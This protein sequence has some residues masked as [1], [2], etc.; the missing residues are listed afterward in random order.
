[1]PLRPIQKLL[2][3]PCVISVL[4]GYGFLITVLVIHILWARS[5]MESQIRDMLLA[6]ASSNAAQI[7]ADALDAVDGRSDMDAPQFRELVTR[8]QAIRDAEGVSIRYAY[9]LRRTSDPMEL[10]FVADADSLLSPDELDVNR[11]GTV[12]MA[13]EASYP[14]DT[15]DVSDNDALRMR[16]FEA[17]TTDDEVTIDQWGRLLSGYAPIRRPNGTVTGVLGIDMKADEYQ[18]LIARTASPFLLLV[19]IT[20]GLLLCATSVYCVV[21]KMPKMDTNDPQSAL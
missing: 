11:N 4:A 19:V 1:M 15:Y 12:D 6:L 16:A 2:H 21:K 7:D 17:P 8:L 5:T 14:G 20:S 9:I 3:E 10:E 18:S 13:E